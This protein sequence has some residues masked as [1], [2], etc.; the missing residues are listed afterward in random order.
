MFIVP[1]HITYDSFVNPGGNE[2]A[3]V[4]KTGNYGSVITDMPLGPLSLSAYLKKNTAVEI[5]LID[6]NIVLNKMESFEY[7]S[8]LELFREFLSAKEWVD[9]APSIIG[10]STLFTPAYYNMVE[11]AQVARDLFP[12]ALIIAGGGVPTNM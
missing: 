9:Y 6:F 10:I 11:V 8:F 2:R 7:S 5:K 4:K 1:P 3:V 12:R